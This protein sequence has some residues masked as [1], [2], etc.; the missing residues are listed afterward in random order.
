MME[1][2]RDDELK[3]KERTVYENDPYVPGMI[4]FAPHGRL[5]CS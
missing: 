2:K 4:P 5:Q 1:R 3:R